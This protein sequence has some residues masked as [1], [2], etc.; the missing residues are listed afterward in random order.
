MET[1]PTAIDSDRSFY[2]ISTCYRFACGNRGGTGESSHAEQYIRT[3]GQPCAYAAACA[4]YSFIPTP[5]AWELRERRC[6]F[7][8]GA[9]QATI[10]VTV[11]EPNRAR[12]LQ[13]LAPRCRLRQSRS[14][15]SPTASPARTTWA[16]RQLLLPFCPACSAARRA[17]I[18]K[19]GR[20]DGDVFNDSSTGSNLKSVSCSVR[21]EGHLVL[22]E[23]RSK[24]SALLLSV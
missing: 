14:A 17:L 10:G 24:L 18:E 6:G 5:A 20:N 23:K 8:V 11:C 2:L 4:I 16:R 7:N 21:W 22:L 3:R 1:A 12:W 19:A 13:P 9:A 15:R